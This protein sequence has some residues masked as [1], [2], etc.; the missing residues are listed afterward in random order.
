MQR[1][2]ASTFSSDYKKVWLEKIASGIDLN[3]IVLDRCIFRM[4][5]AARSLRYMLSSTVKYDNPDYLS[6]NRFRSL[7]FSS[8][9]KK[10]L[11]L[12]NLVGLEL[13]LEI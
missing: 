9:S 10:L 11:P 6:K 13:I 12:N 5:Q 3:L 1:H 2:R 8:D 7:T 4:L